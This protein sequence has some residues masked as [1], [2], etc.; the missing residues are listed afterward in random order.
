MVCA[1][2]CYRERPLCTQ[3]MNQHSQPHVL[4]LLGARKWIHFTSCSCV[5]FT[6]TT[7]QSFPPVSNQATNLQTLC[8]YSS[9]KYLMLEQ[10][11]L[12][13]STFPHQCGGHCDQQADLIC[14]F[15]TNFVSFNKVQQFDSQPICVCEVDAEI[16]KRSHD[17]TNPVGRININN[18]YGV[19]MKRISH[20][21]CHFAHCLEDIV[22]RWLNS[23]QNKRG[24]VFKGQT[25][26]VGAKHP[27]FLNSFWVLLSLNTDEGYFCN[28]SYHIDL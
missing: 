3:H 13:F 10:N 23:E 9:S 14:S 18:S 19:Y 28:S 8:N 20:L 24:T 26:H 6:D 11:S 4:D 2:Q 27:G 16:T 25:Q 21:L 12:P 7:T 17:G 1:V 15:D 22:P 5:Y